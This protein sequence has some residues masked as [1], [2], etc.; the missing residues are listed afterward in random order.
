MMCEPKMVGPRQRSVSLHIWTDCLPTW[1]A[2]SLR[3]NGDIA[4]ANVG[5]S[6]VIEILVLA[7]A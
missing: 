5:K 2:V 6:A 3:Q 4:A 1:L 7:D